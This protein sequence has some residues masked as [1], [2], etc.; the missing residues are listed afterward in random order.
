MSPPVAQCI[1][2]SCVALLCLLFIVQ[3]KT[4]RTRVRRNRWW[5]KFI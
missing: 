5:Q 4:K 3:Q 1:K 2:F